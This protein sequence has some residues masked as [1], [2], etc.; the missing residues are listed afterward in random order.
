MR[1][2]LIT[3]AAVMIFMT[4]PVLSRDKPKSREEL[5]QL[6]HHHYES[7][8]PRLDIPYWPTYSTWRVSGKI[9]EANLFES[10]VPIWYYKL[11]DNSFV[12][13]GT[14]EIGTPLNLEKFRTVEHKNYY[15]VPDESVAL[16]TTI[17]PKLLKGQ[18]YI[19]G[20]FVARDPADSFKPPS[21]FTRKELD[22]ALKP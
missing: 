1:M 4:E 13:V 2:L 6:I 7:I 14:I 22:A 12:Y 17:D 16:E 20:T 19:D 9:G 21:R 10:K 11:E 18:M 8:T 3:S 5:W 15:K